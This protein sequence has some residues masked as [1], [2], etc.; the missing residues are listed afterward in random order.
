MNRRRGKLIWYMKATESE[1]L[2]LSRFTSCKS[3]W[4]CQ[5]W[6]FV[7]RHFAQL[8]KLVVRHCQDRRISSSNLRRGGNPRDVWL[9]PGAVAELWHPGACDS[10]WVRSGCHLSPALLILHPPCPGRNAS[11]CRPALALQGVQKST[12]DSQLNKDCAWVF[13]FWVQI[14][15]FILSIKH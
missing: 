6:W 15:G 10:C 9:Q 3:G 7:L 11:P 2:F 4:L 12:P 1:S 5:P 8:L 13:F 14:P